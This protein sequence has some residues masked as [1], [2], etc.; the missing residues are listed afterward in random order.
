MSDIIL[1]LELKIGAHSYRIERMSVFDQMNVASE[2]RD[3]LVGLAML[4]RDRP[5]DMTDNDYYRTAQ[6]MIMSRAGLSEEARTRIVNICFNQVSRRSGVG[7]QKILAAPGTMQFADI[8]LA[9]ATRLLY[10]SFEHN[11]FLDFFSESP[12]DLGGQ[13]TEDSGPV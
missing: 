13:A 11:R 9:E 10:A 4:K 7:W 6:F 2:M 3:I 5:K 8:G 1:E 12:S